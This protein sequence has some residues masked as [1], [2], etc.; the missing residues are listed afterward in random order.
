M[1]IL[2]K[3]LVII[4]KLGGR[5]E[6]Q[7]AALAYKGKHGTLLIVC[8]GAGG[9][10]GGS[11]ASKFVTNYLIN[12]FK[13]FDGKSDIK[14]YLITNILSC[15][16][17]LLEIS[18]SDS[19]LEGMKTTLCMAYIAGSKGISFH[20]GD[21]RVYQIRNERIIFKTK[22][23][24]YVQDLIKKKEITEKQ[25][26]NHPKS[27]VINRALGAGSKLEIE[28]SDLQIKKNDILFLSTDG[29][30]GLISDDHILKV[31]KSEKTL[32]LIGEKLTDIC[33]SEGIKNKQSKHDNLT[34]LL[35]TMEFKKTNFYQ[36]KKNQI[37]LV[38][39][40]FIGFVI[41]IINKQFD[42]KSKDIAKQKVNVASDSIPKD[43]LNTAKVDSIDID[44]LKFKKTN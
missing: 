5:S 24:S 1:K 18:S 35:Y 22:D 38:L 12:S 34:A 13:N 43:T 42:N 40:L 41:F 17:E 4:S 6:N 32:A 28:I 33:D 30:H 11:Y 44:S 26:K 2:E 31:F 15:N 27:N 23:H 10:N 21:S 16:I 14:E 3:D 37:L 25:A 20:V 39:L 19:V 9:Y 29:I 8:D 36:I 7:D